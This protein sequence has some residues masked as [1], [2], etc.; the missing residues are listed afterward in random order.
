MRSASLTTCPPLSGYCFGDPIGVYGRPAPE[1]SLTAV[2]SM[3]R[4]ADDFFRVAGI[5]LL[6]GRL[7]EQQDHTR[8]T[9]VAV[10]DERFAETYFPGENPIGQRVFTTTDDE[11]EPYEIVDVVDHT[12]TFNLRSENRPPQLY[13]PLLSHTS[14]NTPNVG[15]VRYIVRA[16]ADAD[17]LVPAVRRELAD[18]DPNLALSAVTTL[19]RMLADDRASMAFAM[20]LIVIAGSVALM[21]GMIGIYGVVSY[22]VSRR[23]GEIGVRMAMGARPGSVAAMILRQSGAVIGVGLGIGLAAA[24][25]AGNLLEAM[26]F[27]VSTT[28]PATYAAVVLG[29]LVVSL[30]ACWLPARRAA[31]LN[32]VEALRS[33]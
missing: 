31:A 16:S 3:R 29:L 19:E 22:V 17:A 1:G 9:R 32:P 26:L 28:D 6:G 13:L 4:V 23:T 27:E 2:T 25:A 20:V 10:V 18:M 30:L 11:D 24:L 7:F 21:L 15:A 5:R 33:E 14:A 8:P 12:V